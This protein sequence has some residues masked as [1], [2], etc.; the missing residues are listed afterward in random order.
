LRRELGLDDVVEMGVEAEN[1]VGAYHAADV[2]VLTSVSEAFP[3]SILEAMS[4]GRPVVATDVGGVREAVESSGALVAP[5]DAE[6]LAVEVRRLLDD[7]G[8]RAQLGER[9]RATVVER[10]RVDHTIA[11]Y[12]A[13]YTELAERA[14]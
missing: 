1:I 9:A 4:C 7:P 6:G 5:R 3:Y 14:A 13:L 12:L 10:F 11:R 8:L 2:V